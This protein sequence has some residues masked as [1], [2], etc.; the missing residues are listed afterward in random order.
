MPGGEANRL[1]ERSKLEKVLWLLFL[2]TLPLVNPWVRGDGV[3][4]YAYVRSLLIDHDLNF[5]NEWRAGNSTFALPKV[6]E[7]GRL[8][9][10]V[11][12]P[13]KRVDNHFTVGPAMLWAPFLVVTHGIVKGLNAAGA[14]IPADGYSRPYIWTMGLATALYA[15]VGLL[16][17]FGLARNYFEE[18][19]AF[20]ATLGIWFGSSLPV[21]MYFNPSW[22]HAHSAF[23]VALFLW[24]WH[25]TRGPRSPL[26]WILLGLLGGLMMDVY[27]PNAV[28]LI[29]PL[30]ES[31]RSYGERWFTSERSAVIA[32][33]LV[34]NLLFAA[35]TLVALLPTLITRRIIYGSIL[36]TGYPT[37]SEWL[38]T[39]P[40]LWSVLFS[41]NHG[42]VSWTPILGV[43]L[44]GLLFVWPRDRELTV[45]LVAA[46]L[47]Y[48]YLIASF[49]TWHG[50]SSYGNRFFVS[51][52]PLFVIGLA[53]VF[54]AVEE[55]LGR[56]AVPAAGIVTV[57][58]VLWNAGLI[59]QWGTLM[60]S[61]RGPISFREV[62][63]NQVTLVPA[64]IF[65][66]LKTYLQARRTMMEQIEKK[67]AKQLQSARPE[68]K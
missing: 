66:G 36:E 8:R 44:V 15:F 64:R 24:Y 57:L 10:E 30:L 1:A 31:L 29:L 17:S 52:T 61:P 38:W 13:T 23:A 28:L 14:A 21:Y 58:L 9:P 2:L 16:L 56:S 53:A 46:F 26:Q 65:T 67:D 25:R 20:L 5:E 37:P 41:S 33:L 49:A 35:A 55:R 51:L 7:S 22:S 12:T 62:A 6:D 48:Y 3:G 60:V 59:F 11:Y 4:Y 39:K 18:R 32:R 19:W 40:Q 54:A 43:A 47:A 50:I 45:C 68:G 63:R 34:G 42:L 27:Y